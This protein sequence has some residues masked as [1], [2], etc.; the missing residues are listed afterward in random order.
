MAGDWPCPF[1]PFGLPNLE[2]L[3]EHV[4]D[5]HMERANDAEAFATVECNQNRLQLL[6][7][8]DES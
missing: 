2:R 3:K 4:H 7:A 8:R 5:N 6:A 1:C